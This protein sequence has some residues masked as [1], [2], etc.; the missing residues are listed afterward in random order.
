MF[1]CPNDRGRP[2]SFPY[3]TCTLSSQHPDAISAEDKPENLTRHPQATPTIFSHSRTLDQSG[4]MEISITFPSPENVSLKTNSLRANVSWIQYSSTPEDTEGRETITTRQ[5]YARGSLACKA[6]SEWRFLL[7]I[8]RQI[9]TSGEHLASNLW[10]STA[11]RSLPPGEA[12][13]SACSRTCSQRMAVRK[14]FIYA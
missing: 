1:P 12:V 6:V 8:L 2:A 5:I 3:P 9:P 13:H 14:V 7:R 11:P 10:A 4:V